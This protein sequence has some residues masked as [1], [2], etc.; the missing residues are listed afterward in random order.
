MTFTY[1]AIGIIHSPFQEKFG[2]PRQSMMMKEARALLKL[3]PEPTYAL[4]LSHLEQFS[5]V[6]IIFVFHKN[7]RARWHPMIETPR[8]E[9]GHRMGVFATRSPHRPNP[10]GMSAVKLERIDRKASGGIE[11]H[12][13]GIDLLDGTPVLDIKPYLPYADL[14]P[15]ANS[16]WVKTE[17]E[18]FPV[19]FSVASLA[20]I[21]KHAARGHPR[22]KNLIEQML[23]IDPR[24]LSQRRCSPI[25]DPATEGM[26]FAFR[27]LGLDVHWRVHRN[28]LYVFN[29]VELSAE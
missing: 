7:G 19:A 8:V 20:V 5:H 28:G 21:E 29:V 3:N 25:Q 26:R 2:V 24:P 14:I 18:R 9:A 6:W 17:I 12:L 1:E 15:D 4:A 27:I 11:L 10:I 22:L 16:G 13:S 23:E